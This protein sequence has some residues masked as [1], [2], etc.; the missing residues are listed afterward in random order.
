MQQKGK[1][2]MFAVPK[3]SSPILF[4]TVYILQD[5]HVAPKRWKGTPLRR[6]TAEQHESN[7]AKIDSLQQDEKEKVEVHLGF[8]EAGKVRGNWR[9]GKAA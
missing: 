6:W 7:S 8:K 1:C 4:S 2:Q 9:N 3:A 5:L